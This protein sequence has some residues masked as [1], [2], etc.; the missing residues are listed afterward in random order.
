MSAK[1]AGIYIHVSIPVL[2]QE[3][4]RSEI[5]LPCN[6]PVKVHIF[7]ALEQIRFHI[8][9]GLSQGSDQLL[10][11]RPFGSAGSIL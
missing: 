4:M 2:L 5:L 1:P 3:G 8:G 10:G 6:H 9:I 11:F 7:R